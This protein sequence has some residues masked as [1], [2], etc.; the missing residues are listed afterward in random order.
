MSHTV[1]LLVVY[2][3]RQLFEEVVAIA[4]KLCD[5]VKS[6]ANKAAEGDK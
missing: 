5:Y 6:L 1:F 2:H 4:N 3:E